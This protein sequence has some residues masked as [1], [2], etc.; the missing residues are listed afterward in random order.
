M[1]VNGLPPWMT[2]AAARAGSC[3]KAAGR[4]SSVSG[5]VSSSAGVGVG[6]GRVGA[7]GNTAAGAG[8]G[9]LAV[10]ARPG[11]AGAPRSSTDPAAS[12][13]SSGALPCLASQSCSAESTSSG[14][15]WRILSM[16]MLRE[17]K[18]KVNWVGSKEL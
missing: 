1:R 15:R 14:S 17:K 13:V 7:Q 18:W 9:Q 11:R 5:A 8:Q 10:L 16:S 12:G 4:P 3:S 6:V 2:T